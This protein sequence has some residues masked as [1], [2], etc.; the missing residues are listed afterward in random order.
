MT[1]DFV[2]TVCLDGIPE[3]YDYHAYEQT[4]DAVGEAM[5]RYDEEPAK[6]ITLLLSRKDDDYRAGQKPRFLDAR[7]A[8]HIL[9]GDQLDDPGF[10]P[11]SAQFR[12]G[13]DVCAALA[14]HFNLTDKEYKSLSQT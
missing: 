3:A 14:T 12:S 13:A 10:D 1:T 6:I 2:L 4:I 8:A 9:F 5:C 11:R 7:G